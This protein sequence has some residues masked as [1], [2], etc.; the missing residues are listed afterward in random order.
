MKKSFIVGFISLCFQGDVVNLDNF[1]SKAIELNLRNS[2]FVD[3]T[4]SP[5]IAETY[6]YFLKNNINVVTCNK[7]ACAD[8]FKNYK[9]LKNISKNLKKNV[10][11]LCLLIDQNL[12]PIHSHV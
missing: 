12:S 4:A 2:V 11:N 9:E 3:N 6:K 1:F 5:K 10:H 8:S 7:I